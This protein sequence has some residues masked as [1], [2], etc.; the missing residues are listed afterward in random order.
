M[1]TFH[2]YLT[3]IQYCRSHNIPEDRIVKVNFHTWQV[4]T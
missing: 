3:A 2:Y 1:K 4:Q